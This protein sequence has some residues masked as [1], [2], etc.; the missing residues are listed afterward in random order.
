MQISHKIDK[1]L[2]E[3]LVKLFFNTAIYVFG[4][5]FVIHFANFFGPVNLTFGQPK[6][7]RYSSNGQV[8]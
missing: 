8:E 1:E 7:E 5:Y 3:K 2:N 6:S 4:L